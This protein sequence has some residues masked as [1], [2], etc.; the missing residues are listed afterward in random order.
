MTS[1]TRPMEAGHARPNMAWHVALWVAQIALAGMFGFAGFMKLTTPMAQLHATMAWTSV[2]PDLLVRFIGLSELAG[3]L[4]LILPA[5]T[6]VQP[7][8][9]PL[10]A[11]GLAAIMVLAIGF[12]GVRGEFF[13]LP[14]TIALGV[15]A[16]FVAW[17]R[18]RKAPI[19][20]R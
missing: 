3:A 10:A 18:A 14:I 12:H 5:L 6:R 15:A 11:L 4:G 20:S 2:T 1:A 16:A 13:A 17:G 9:T 7:K 19:E 8:L